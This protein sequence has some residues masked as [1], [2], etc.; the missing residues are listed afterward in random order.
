MSLVK[1]AIVQ[2]HW[3]AALGRSERG[4]ITFMAPSGET[5]SF[6]GE[7]DGPSAQFRIREWG[8]LER[9]VARGDIGLGEDYIA[10]A[11][12]T[13]DLE[14]LIAFFLVNLAELE[15][16]AHGGFLQRLAFKLHNTVVRRNSESGSRRNIEA[17]Y[18]VGNDFYAL[19]L[20]ETMTYSSALFD[21]AQPSLA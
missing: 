17:H 5:W 16:F 10:G 20:D 14:A 19:W 8:V 12:E 2:D 6:K 13:N 15:E 4:Q 9:L 1:N 3:L 18:D 11:W 21:G 7:R